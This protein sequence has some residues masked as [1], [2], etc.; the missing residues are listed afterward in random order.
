MVT[1]NGDTVRIVLNREIDNSNEF[2]SGKGLSSK[3]ANDLKEKNLGFR[4]A[5]IGKQTQTSIDITHE[6]QNA[7]IEA[8]LFPVNGEKNLALAGRIINDMA[9]KGFGRDSVAICIDEGDG[10]ALGSFIAAVYAR[11]IPC[12]HYYK[13]TIPPNTSFDD[14]L[15]LLKQPKITYYDGSFIENVKTTRIVHIKQI[16]ESHDI[17][18]GHDM[19]SRFARDLKER[20]L[21]TRYALITDSNVNELYANRISWEMEKL[22]LEHCI[23]SFTA[24]E[25]SKSLDTVIKIIGEMKA[26]GFE[27][28]AIVCI[29]GGV[30]TDLGGFIAAMRTLPCVYYATTTA[31]QADAAIGG[32]TGVNIPIAKNLI[33][34]IKQPVLIYLDV[35]TI[36]TQSFRGYREGLAEAVKHG[37]IQDKEFFTYLSL[38]VDDLANCQTDNLENIIRQ[39]V[40]IK[41]TVIE[42]DPFEKGLRQ[43]LNYGHT[44]GHAVEASE[45]GK[46]YHGEAVSCGMMAEG[47]IAVEMGLYQ[48]QQLM[49]QK[50]VLE[51]L[52][53]PVRI[54]LNIS[55]E[56]IIATT[57]LDKK[58]REGK[59]RY[60]LPEVIGKMCDFNGNWATYVDKEVVLK[61]LDKTR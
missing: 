26:R 6:L 36:P 7:G 58:A 46:M 48:E 5:L 50:T 60:V 54:P 13:S 25:K 29:G 24:G 28:S 27:N 9:S 10:T 14:G 19:I 8:H 51:R 41:G 35:A 55:N 49:Q 52:R 42:Q 31:S 56:E 21:S 45:Y 11:G 61:A 59:A 43:I 18:I 22:G 20:N 53:L 4:H 32:K 12:V 33:G 44:I 17:I 57:L 47:W 2:I 38:N 15:G 1:I 37:I 3:L 39:N 34:M 16:N 30:V 40:I 23:F